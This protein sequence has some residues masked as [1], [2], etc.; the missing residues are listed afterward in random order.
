MINRWPVA[1]ITTLVNA[2]GMVALVSTLMVLTLSPAYANNAEQQPV[3]SVNG[4]GV[5]TMAPDM[6]VLTLT[7]M[8]EAPTARAALTA[9]SR[10]MSEVIAA[11]KSSG[12]ASRDL[13]TSGLSIQ[14]QYVYPKRNDQG[15]TRKL[16]GYTVRNTLTVRVRDMDNVGT[17]LDQSVS[18]GVNEGGSIA[19]TNDDPSDA[20]QQARKSAVAIA[21]EKAQTLASA[22]GVR[23]GKVLTITEQ[24]FSRGPSP[25]VARMAVMDAA[26]SVPVEAGE[27]SYRVNV[28]MTFA[29]E[30]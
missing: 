9:S 27:N 19:F 1:S 10:A 5:S 12:V 25:Y 23:L 18:L 30:Q 7:V 28:Q 17:V 8:R 4:E 13:Q 11:M 24:S 26:E 3:I 21:R 2:L 6:A 29:I 16:T 22:A 15:E 14:P 20:L